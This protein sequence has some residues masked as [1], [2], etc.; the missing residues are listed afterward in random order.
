MRYIM[1]IYAD[2]PVIENLD[3]D[4]IM[5]EYFAFNAETKE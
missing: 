4:A 3:S 2:E 5:E 1:L